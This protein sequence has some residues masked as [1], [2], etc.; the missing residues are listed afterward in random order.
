SICRTPARSWRSRKGRG[1]ASDGRS[2]RSGGTRRSF[3]RGSTG[4]SGVRGHNKTVHFDVL[5][6][7]NSMKRISAVLT[8]MALAGCVVVVDDKR[9]QPP[10]PQHTETVVV[11]T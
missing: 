11:Y 8:L 7:G 1:R 5:R 9:R 3:C 2:G 6:K 4:L 10:P